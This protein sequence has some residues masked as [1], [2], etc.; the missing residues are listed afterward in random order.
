[1]SVVYAVIVIFV[2]TLLLMMDIYNKNERVLSF[3]IFFQHVPL[4]IFYQLGNEIIGIIYF[5]VVII[6]YYLRNPKLI[7]KKSRLVNPVSISVMLIFLSLF[8]HYFNLGIDRDNIIGYQTFNR[9]IIFNVPIIILCLIGISSNEKMLARII[10]GIVL[11]G[12][13]FLLTVMF[14]TGLSEY[15]IS[16]RGLFRDDFRIS[17]LVAAKTAG[18]IIIAN[19]FMLINETR[20]T[21]RIASFLVMVLSIALLFVT[22]S[23]GAV[24]FLFIAMALYFGMS[25][26]TL[27][28]KLLIISVA[29]IFIFVLYAVINYLNLPIIDR[30]QELQNY[31]QMSRYIRLEYLVGMVMRFEMGLFGLGPFGFGHQTGLHYPHNYIAE[32]VVD[33]GLLGIASAIMFTGFGFYYS[34]TLIR[35]DYQKNSAFIAILFLYLYLTSLTSGDIVEAR[36]MQFVGIIMANTYFYVKYENRRNNQRAINENHKY[37]TSSII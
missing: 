22:A 12:F 37:Q 5:V 3:V 25:A 28:R 16:D 11:Y 32:L 30:I 31:E 35:N 23:R 9:V 10:E 19:V 1:M 24:L 34:Y 6:L 18:I 26:F 8:I 21:T 27:Y 2:L 14:V 33:Y 4:I 7:I 15:G 17:P 13:V 36:H 20:A 29:A